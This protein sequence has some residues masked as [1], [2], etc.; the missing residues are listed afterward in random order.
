MTEQQAPV[1]G[2]SEAG[3][4]AGIFWEPKPVFQDLAAR[5]RFWVPLILLTVLSVVYMV[6]FSQRVGWE[7]MMRR[8]FE[9]N[10]RIQQLPAEQRER[11]IQQ[12]LAFTGPMATGGAV[13]GMAVM[14]LAIA[15]VLLGM[16]N[17]LGGA[18]LKYR[19]ALSI[20]CYSFLPSALASILALVILFLKNPEDFDLRNPLPLNLGAII[21]S[22]ETAGWLKALAR[23]M[24]LFTFWIIAL[25]ALG[26]STAAGKKLS[27]SKALVLV[28]IPWAVAAL[29][30][31][32]LAG[33][34]G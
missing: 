8:Q 24:D 5:P 23:S 32:A 28:V 12:Q 2:M 7:S 13:L 27:F 26:F 25:M 34:Q 9:A 4:L 18:G 21:S 20:T 17:L 16:M 22:P 33:L 14:S 3:R 6:S 15:G 1:A 19:Q 29:I 11:L 31:A 10:S 30:G